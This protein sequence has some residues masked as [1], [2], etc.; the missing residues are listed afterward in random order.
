MLD[1]NE[2]QIIISGKGNMIM[3][4]IQGEKIIRIY[5]ISQFLIK[6]KSTTMNDT[7]VVAEYNGQEKFNQFDLTY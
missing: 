5:E 2:Q 7:W 6:V 3:E 1:R 4:F